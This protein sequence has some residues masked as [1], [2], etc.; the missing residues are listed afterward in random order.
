MTAVRPADERGQLIPRWAL[1]LDRPQ[2]QSGKVVALGEKRE[3]VPALDHHAGSKRVRMHPQNIGVLQE[4]APERREISLLPLPFRDFDPDTGRGAMNHKSPAGC[5]HLRSD[6][7]VAML[8]RPQILL[9]PDE[10]TV[11]VRGSR[12]ARAY[13]P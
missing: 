12:A 3:S 8:I 11:T 7:G 13:Q 4:G 6:G 1:S 5:V 10:A 9:A 2:L